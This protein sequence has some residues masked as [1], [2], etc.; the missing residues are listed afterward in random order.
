LE[1]SGDLSRVLIIDLAVLDVISFSQHV[2]GW[3]MGKIEG[4]L[5]Q[6]QKRN[7][8]YDDVMQVLSIAPPFFFLFL[9]LS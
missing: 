9:T 3:E 2:N 1:V 7:S 8:F 5:L 4:D 6:A